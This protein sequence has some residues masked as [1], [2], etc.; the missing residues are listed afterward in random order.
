MIATCSARNPILVAWLVGLSLFLL[1]P[2]AWPIQLF[3]F[4][5]S[6]LLAAA[7]SVVGLRQV[8]STSSR[9][10]LLGG[11]VLL[12]VLSLAAVALMMGDREA[13][14][15]RILQSL[16]LTTVVG[17]VACSACLVG[18]LLRPR[19]WTRTLAL[20]PALT[21]AC[22]VVVVALQMPPAARPTGPAKE[23]LVLA[24][25]GYAMFGAGGFLLIGLLL[26]AGNASAKEP[27]RRCVG[28]IVLVQVITAFVLS[29][30]LWLLSAFRL[31][32]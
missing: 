10:L 15:T 8:P 26:G 21:A 24:W 17:G 29:A 16:L 7:V 31:A 12:V 5:A 30:Y 3:A 6:P 32:G 22:F 19:W 28:T 14:G 27:R 20:L 13:V 1:A 4:V 11:T 23:E 9:V 18:V 25:L 2:I